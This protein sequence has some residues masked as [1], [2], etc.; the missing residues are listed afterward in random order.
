ML[1][2]GTNILKSQDLTKKKKKRNVQCHSLRQPG[3]TN[4]SISYKKT[5]NKMNRRKEEK[6]KAFLFT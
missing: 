3:S 6:R 1:L 2:E 4:W 5:Q